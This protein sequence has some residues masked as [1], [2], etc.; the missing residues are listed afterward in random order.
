MGG[1]MFR[2]CFFIGLFV[3]FTLALI[4]IPVSAQDQASK[5][6]YIY[7]S[8]WA[9]PRSMWPEM[10]KQETANRALLDK[11]IADGTITSY[12]EFMNLVH[13]EGEPT[14]GDWFQSSTQAGILHVLAALYEQAGVTSPVYASSKH[15]DYFLETDTSESAGTSGT[16]TNAYL[17]VFAFQ[18]KKGQEQNFDHLYKAYIMPVYQK[19]VSEGTLLYYGLDG[20]NVVTS[21]PGDIES[22]IIAANPE[23]LDK[24]SAALQ[25]EFAKNP[26]AIQALQATAKRDTVRSFLSLVPYMKVK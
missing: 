1:N 20:Q 14:H 24:V 22:V 21:N 6:V 10:T 11:F 5:P 13:Q 9:V 15:W 16:F 2:R 17:R 4:A 12:G 8:E 7:V 25:A 26:A 19:L 18:V 3:A 23:A